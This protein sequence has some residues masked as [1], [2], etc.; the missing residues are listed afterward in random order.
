MATVPSLSREDFLQ[1]AEP[2]AVELPGGF[3]VTVVPREFSTGS[4]GR[5]FNGPVYV[6]VD[7]RREKVMANISLPLAGSKR[8]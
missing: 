3:V 6:T 5:G 7:G 1:K 4:F 2:F 8:T